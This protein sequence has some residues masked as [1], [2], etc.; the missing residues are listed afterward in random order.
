MLSIK[1][2][3]VNHLW[4]ISASFRTSSS[5]LNEYFFQILL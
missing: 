1:I 3:A 4:N 5:D 2:Q